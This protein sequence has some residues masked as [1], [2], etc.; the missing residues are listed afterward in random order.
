[1]NILSFFIP[2][3][4]MIGLAAGNATRFAL[5]PGL[6]FK[7]TL[8]DCALMISVVV[9]GVV[10][11]ARRQ[12]GSFLRW[13]W[14]HRVW[15]WS[16][17]FFAWVILDFLITA[18]GFT[19]RESVSAS[20]YTMRL[21]ATFLIIWSMHFLTPLFREKSVRFFLYACV[22]LLMLGIL[23][24]VAFPDFA[25]MTIDGWDPHYYRFLSTFYDPN[26]LGIFLPLGMVWALST[27]LQQR[28][29]IRWLY[30]ALW[31]LSWVALYFSYSRTGWLTAFVALM[32]FL[33]KASKKLLILCAIIFLGVLVL[34]NRLGQRFTEA[35]IC[36]Q[37]TAI[38]LDSE[39]DRSGSTRLESYREAWSIIR[40][41]PIIGVGYNRYLPAAQRAARET[42]KDTT[43][44]LNGSHSSLLNLFA[45]TGIIGLGLWCVLW[46]VIALTL[47]RQ[48]KHAHEEWGLGAWA[49][50]AYL[51]ALFVGSI[52]NN[53]WL[54]SPIL[55]SFL[56]MV[57]IVLPATVATTAVQ[58]ETSTLESNQKQKV[59]A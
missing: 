26:L 23:I 54:F 33:W 11:I 59:G 36:K 48:R 14:C 56:M 43:T 34:P 35:K 15:K 47:W 53:G 29:R 7:V 32:L 37:D 25:F 10:L 51:C 17:I 42:G 5:L 9:L 52:F 45:T 12:I 24:Y 38:S 49:L 3:I 6:S 22:A 57:S 2:A 55:L 20:A 4:L 16:I 13:L 46:G 58:H 21:I 18:R 8:L 44:V 1:M 30:H 41:H 39:C 27:A 28:G 50:L 40:E 19:I 31:I